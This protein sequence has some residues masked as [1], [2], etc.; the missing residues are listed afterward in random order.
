[1]KNRPQSRKALYRGVYSVSH[2]TF[3]FTFRFAQ[4]ILTTTVL[5][6]VG[7]GWPRATF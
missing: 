1:M 6:R 3:F 4:E 7:H 5:C 2:K